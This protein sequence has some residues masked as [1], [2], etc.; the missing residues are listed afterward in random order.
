MSIDKTAIQPIRILV[1]EHLISSSVC[2][3]LPSCSR[4]HL[5]CNHPSIHQ[6]PSQSGC[7]TSFV[8]LLSDECVH[9]SHALTDMF[10]CEYLKRSGIGIED[11]QEMI[12]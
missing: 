10:A 1:P 6:A 2:F 8:H 7:C 9:A 4:P 12:G 11:G 5:D 3:C